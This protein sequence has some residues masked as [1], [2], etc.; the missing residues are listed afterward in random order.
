LKTAVLDLGPSIFAEAQAYVA[1]SRISSL[2]GVALIQLSVK[3][4]TNYVKDADAEYERLRSLVNHI[5]IHFGDAETNFIE[6]KQA[7]IGQ[8]IEHDTHA[9]N[10]LHTSVTAELNDDDLDSIQSDLTS[11][12]STSNFVI[13]THVSR[14]GRKTRPNPRYMGED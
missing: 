1:L 13:P 8:I 11:S 6:E 2:D 9:T 14:A 5:P 7:E 10:E 3:T 4:L 12:D